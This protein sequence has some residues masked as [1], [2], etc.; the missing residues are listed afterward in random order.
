M[1]KHY[2]T[3]KH[4]KNH[5]VEM[6][7]P[8]PQMDFGGW[9]KQGFKQAG[10]L[11]MNILRSDADIALSTVG[12]N[13]VVKDNSYSGTGSQLGRTMGNIGGG[14]TKQALPLVAGIAGS[15]MASMGI[16]ALQQGLGAI[17]PENSQISSYKMGGKMCYPNGGM[18]PNAELEKQE[19][20][21]APDGT[22]EQF[23]GPS[24][25]QGGI[26]V[27]LAPGEMIFS[28]KLKSKE[29]NKT[30]AKSAKPYNTEKEEKILKDEKANHMRKLTA[31][32]MMKAKN[33]KLNQI[34]DEQEGQ[35]KERIMRYAS[36]MGYDVAPQIQGSGDNTVMKYG[37]MKKYPDG[38][39]ADPTDKRGLTST[40][41]PVNATQNYYTQRTVGDTTNY[42]KF[43]GPVN[44]YT[45]PSK[46]DSLPQGL[47]PIDAA[48]YQQQLATPSNIAVG[49]I[50]G[51]LP[52]TIPQI[53][54]N[55][56][57][58]KKYWDGGKNDDF[59]SYSNINPLLAAQQFQ[60]VNYPYTQE[61][62]NTQSNAGHMGANFAISNQG[63]INSTTQS[64]SNQPFTFNQ[65]PGYGNTIP[66]NYN[67]KQPFNLNQNQKDLIQS[68]VNAI[69][70]NIGNLAY[71]HDQGKRY[72]KVNYGQINPSYLDP[73][74]SL[75][76]TDSQ[77]RVAR[78]NIS[79]YA[80]G[81]GGAALSNIADV[82]SQNS[83]N[84]ARVRSE[85]D[86]ANVGIKNQSLQFNKEI[87]MRGMNDEAANKGQALTNYYQAL[88][89]TG[90]K[91]AGA[92]RDYKGDKNDQIRSNLLNDLYA[93]YKYNPTTN[94]WETK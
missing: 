30:F 23:D 84:K 48:T 83:I 45:T 5:P 22:T 73:T 36:K 62:I 64:N 40:I 89:N 80:G 34:F 12:L 26:P 66:S 67:P 50:N 3:P 32:L 75:R 85:Y 33:M 2:K 43:S 16:S 74:A 14:L 15:P 17:N 53:Q 77:A 37:G 47:I 39:I 76:D 19:N 79:N 7:P 21:L 1:K 57:M 86:N 6:Y 63:N 60:Q 92:Y 61:D 56:G 10:D 42:Y 25:E 44:K 51:D 11:G 90:A 28:D 88:G 69:G 24:H 82:M 31:D 4:P 29:T 71:L 59:S 41:N 35:K 54:R 58:I 93:N 46:F 18:Q 20:T 70:Q 27:K 52:V 91:T 68:G 49:K 13:N 72:D 81:Q 87:Q 78:E 9:M 65:A 8:I 55:G 38:G 94:K